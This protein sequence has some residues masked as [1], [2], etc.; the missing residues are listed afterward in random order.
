MIGPPARLWAT[1]SP[2]SPRVVVHQF[3]LQEYLG[4]ALHPI[5]GS[6]SVLDE[7]VADILVDDVPIVCGAGLGFLDGPSRNLESVFAR[8]FGPRTKAR[9]KKRN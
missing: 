2:F 5:I 7:L 1:R 8:N 9:D 6:E 3:R 4:G